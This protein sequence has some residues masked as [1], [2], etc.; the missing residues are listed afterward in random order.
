MRVRASVWKDVALRGRRPPTL[1]RPA[2]LWTAHGEEEKAERIE[3]RQRGSEQGISSQGRGEVS[4]RRWRG[5]ETTSEAV[6]KA[7]SKAV[8]KAV[9]EA[10]REAV[11]R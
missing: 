8:G 3:G 5:D 1:A 4:E 10:V 6:S 2:L 11:R 9:G 7:V